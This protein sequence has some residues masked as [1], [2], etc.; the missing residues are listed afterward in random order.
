MAAAGIAHKCQLIKGIKTKLSELIATPQTSAILKPSFRVSC[1]ARIKPTSMPSQNAALVMPIFSGVAF[2]TFNPIGIRVVPSPYWPN[3][4][5][6]GTILSAII[7]RVL[8]LKAA[9]TDYFIVGITNSEPIDLLLAGQRDVVV[10]R[11]V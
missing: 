8:K 1:P 2:L 3:C 5:R 6:T 11:R 7:L 10:L 9:K 4:A